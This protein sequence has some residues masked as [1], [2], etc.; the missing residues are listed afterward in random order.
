[1]KNYY[2]ILGVDRNATPDEIKKTYRKKAMEFHPDRN[3]GDV[4]AEDK[5]KEAT[6]AY[7]IL[8]DENKRR[9]Y[10]TFGTANGSNSGGNPFNMNDIFS[11]FGDIFGGGFGGGGFNQRKRGNDLKVPVNLTLIDV[12]FGSNKKIKYKRQDKCQKC[13]GKGGN[14]LSTCYSCNGQGKKVVV[15]NTPFGRVQQ[16]HLCNIC[17]G[18]G[19]IIQHKCTDCRGEGTIL[20]EETIDIK[21]PA[22]AVNGM[23]I[24]MPGNGNHIRNGDPGDLFIAINEIPDDKFQ[25][26]GTDLNYNHWITISDVVLGV[27]SNIETPHGEININ[28][29]NGCDGGKVFTFKN[30]G[31]PNLSMNGESYSTGSLHIKVNIL[32]PKLLTDEQR[33]LFIKLKD[34]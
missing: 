28:I 27:T 4:E 22:G 16:A 9:N 3:P 7:D 13:D 1:M 25:R 26:D 12:I 6:E 24:N 23:Q 29:P 21:I 11:Q 10:D 31:I 14:D 8:S 5:F 18:T 20:K 30:K 15:Q 33:D 17:D 2:E 19:K 34:L 32:I